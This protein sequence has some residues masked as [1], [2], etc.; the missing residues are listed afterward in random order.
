MNDHES[1]QWSLDEHRHLLFAAWAG[2]DAAVVYDTASG[3]L[4]LI[5]DVAAAV[6]S[7]LGS[8]GFNR[9]EL[10]S[11]VFCEAEPTLAQLETFVLQ[12]LLPLER[13]DLIKKTS[14]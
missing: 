7:R 12:V 9:R 6:L 2:E 8:G 13:L 14:A 1:P 10:F 5:S 11:V 3:D 4:H